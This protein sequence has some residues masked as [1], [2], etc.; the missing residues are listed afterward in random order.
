MFSQANLLDW[1]GKKLN[2]T[3]QKHSFT[4]QKICT[5]NKQKK[6]KAMFSR[7]L[8]RP[9]WKRSGSIPKKRIK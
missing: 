8:R 7:L 6:T 9:A 2:L 5:Q 1:Y 3:Q 4:N